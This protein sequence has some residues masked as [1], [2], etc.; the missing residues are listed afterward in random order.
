MIALP[1]VDP[2]DYIMKAG[3]EMQ[4][5]FNKYL[6]VIP[7]EEAI[8]DETLDPK[9]S[10]NLLSEMGAEYLTELEKL[11]DT[12]PSYYRSS[13]KSAYEVPTPDVAGDLFVLQKAYEDAVKKSVWEKLGKTNYKDVLA[14]KLLLKEY[15]KKYLQAMHASFINAVSKISR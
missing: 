15:G 2:A 14:Y 9:Y 5:C 1:P 7:L 11:W 4:N 8:Q 6:N 10:P 3:D 13:F 12:I